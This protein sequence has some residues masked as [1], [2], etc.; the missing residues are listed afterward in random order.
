MRTWS[1]SIAGTLFAPAVF[2]AA[3]VVV[4]WLTLSRETAIES[5]VTIAVATAPLW[6]LLVAGARPAAH[7]ADFQIL[8]S[9]E[10]P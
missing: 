1:R 3:L 5:L 2:V 8:F 10:T 6:W 7:R 9:A 4:W